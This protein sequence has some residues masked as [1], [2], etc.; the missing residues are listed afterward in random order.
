M[1]KIHDKLEEL[2]KEDKPLNVKFIRL[3]KKSYMFDYCG[4][5]NVAYIGFGTN[6]FLDICNKLKN[7]DTRVG[8]EKE[9]RENLVRVNSTI[10]TNGLYNG[11]FPDGIEISGYKF[12][13]KVS[14]LCN[15]Y[16]W[17]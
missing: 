7:A 13:F 12:Y 10:L 2:L 16:H 17:K 4:K 11:D 15:R 14:I 3:G 6:N 8:A 9:L 1:T 5:N